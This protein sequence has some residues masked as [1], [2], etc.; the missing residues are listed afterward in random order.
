MVVAEALACG[1]PILASRIGS[2][3]ELIHE[4]ETGATFPA[5]DAPALAAK[6]RELLANAST[7]AAMR[8]RSRASFEAELTESRNFD[9]LMRI[10]TDLVRAPEHR[11]AVAPG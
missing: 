5:G 3:E 4:G 9:R 8:V 1:T 7:L 11:P 2:L 10:Y 6:V